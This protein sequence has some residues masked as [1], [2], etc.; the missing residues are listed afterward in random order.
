[1][2]LCFQAVQDR[3]P[4]RQIVCLDVCRGINRMRVCPFGEKGTAPFRRAI[5]RH[6]SDLKIFEDS[7]WEHWETLSH[8]QQI[9]SGIPSKL[10]VTIFA[11]HKRPNQTDPTM[12]DR[13]AKRA[14]E[15]PEIETLGDKPKEESDSPISLPKID[16]EASDVTLKDHKDNPTSITP[17]N[18]PN[19]ITHGPKFTQLDMHTQNQIRKIHQNLGHP[20]HRVLQLALRRYGWNEKE[21]SAVT[22]FSCPVCHEHQHPESGSPWKAFRSTRF[23]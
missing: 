7:Q 14:R 10:L 9:R 8:R 4:D 3:Y 11:S 16:D 2:A 6:R 5:G 19:P 17:N 15:N 12:P 13:E 20:D 21:V 1:M 18:H 23:Q 22:D